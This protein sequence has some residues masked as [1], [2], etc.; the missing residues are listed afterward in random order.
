MEG[1]RVAELEEAAEQRARRFGEVEPRVGSAR[2]LARERRRRERP[3]DQQEVAQLV[4]R[5]IVGGNAAGSTSRTPTRLAA[6]RRTPA[7]AVMTPL[8]LEQGDG[9][10]RGS[11]PVAVGIGRARTGTPSL[12]ATARSTPVGSGPS[13]FATI[14]STARGAKTKPSSNEFDASRFAPCTPEH[15]ASPHDHSRAPSTHRRGRSRRHHRGSARR[16]RPGASPHV[17]RGSPTGRNPRS[18][19]KRSGKSPILVASSQR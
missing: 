15:A 17:G 16:A 8:E 14:A 2:L 11:D 1:Q 19:G 7:P 12:S 10:R 3:S 13:F 6:S 5:G 18:S 9:A 4:A